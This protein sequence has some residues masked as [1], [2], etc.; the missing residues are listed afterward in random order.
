M[1]I[2]K[3]FLEKVITYPSNIHSSGFEAEE[4]VIDDFLKKGYHVIRAESGSV[5]DTRWKVD[6][7]VWRG[8]QLLLVQVKDRGGFSTT[9]PKPPP[10]AIQEW[11]RRGFKKIKNETLNVYGEEIIPIYEKEVM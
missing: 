11:R 8:D 5:A 2:R 1:N 3:A 10:W 9:F 6:L 7:L 4:V